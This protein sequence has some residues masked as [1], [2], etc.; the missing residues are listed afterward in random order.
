[1]ASLRPY[2]VRSIRW[3]DHQKVLDLGG[4]K[5]LALPRS[6]CVTAGDRILVNG[7]KAYVKCIDG[8]AQLLPSYVAYEEL[9]LG[10]L[11]L[12]LVVKEI[13]EAGELA[14]CQSLVSFHYRD[15]PLFGRTSKLIVQSFHPSYPR[16][17]GYIELA[18]PFY[19]NKSRTDV[20][21]R[22]FRNANV[23]W[24]S[25]SKET[26][27]RS[28]N[29]VVRVARCVVYPEF[30]GLGLGQKLFHH[31]RE[32]AK[33]RWQMGGLKPEF[34]EISADMLKYVPFVE[35]AGLHFI[36]ETE[37]NLG[38]VATDLRY[39]LENRKRVRSGQ[40]VKEEAFGIV[41][42]QV[43]RLAHAVTIMRDNGWNTRELLARLTRLQK[44]A[45]LKDL[46]LLQH[47]LS[48]PKPTY[49]G[50]LTLGSEKFVRGAVKSLKPVNGDRQNPVSIKP[51]SK[52]LRIERLSITHSSRVGRSKHTAAVQ[53]A[54]GISPE[55]IRHDVVNDLSLTVA[56]GQ[57]VMLLGPSGSGKTSVLRAIKD[58]KS[59]RKYSRSHG[60]IAPADMRIGSFEQ[61]LSKKPLI[62]ALGIKDVSMA[63]QL[64]GIVSLSDAFVYLKRFD[65]LS[66][67]QQY[68][69]LLAKLIASN[70]NVWLA[71]EFCVN[72]DPVAASSVAQKLG[73]LARSLKAILIV[74]TPQSDLIARSLKPDIVVRLTTAWEHEV[75]DGKA[76]VRHLSP[77]ATSFKTPSIKVSAATMKNALKAGSG[78]S[79]IL[80]GHAHVRA[81][82]SRLY[83]AKRS[84]LVSLIDVRHTSIDA[85]AATEVRK[86][87]FATK[88]AA[89]KRFGQ[90]APV[91]IVEIAR[92]H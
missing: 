27:R 4:A 10:G 38:R 40:I 82:L 29:L 87:G 64:L 88:G 23:A 60:I 19:M 21:N 62:E 20:L 16:T 71:D 36:G 43:S 77:R 53:R 22:P 78:R 85:L 49:F 65:Q 91:T 33:T 26:A 48:L 86:A 45:S 28:I 41:D 3:R 72:L 15:Q 50:G 83:T 59:T 42:Q 1:V 52:P 34:I 66:A 32:F 5:E 7:T 18:S 11:R 35:K 79:V 92:L 51:L 44:S 9:D 46:H 70:T 30:R 14:A 61:I 75:L 54:F 80:P 69:A 2:S 90:H 89:T 81:G 76:F 84:T 24:E 8:M 12:E 17:I 39:L 58:S 25:W 68:R 67:G 56:P 31:A 37:G 74:A 73:K 55:N 63:L 13:T 6:A 47:I 57:V